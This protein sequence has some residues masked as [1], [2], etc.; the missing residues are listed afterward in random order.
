[1][2]LE[3]LATFDLLMVAHLKMLRF[4]GFHDI[5]LP[6]GCD[7]CLL[8]GIVNSCLPSVEYSRRSAFLISL[9]LYYPQL[10]CHLSTGQINHIM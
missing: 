8:K 2:L 6:A 3:Q 4:L 5:M 7:R 9:P 10:P 1:M